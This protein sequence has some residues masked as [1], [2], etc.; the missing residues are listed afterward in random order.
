MGEKKHQLI[1]KWE[2]HP[3]PPLPH[4]RLTEDIPVA[5]WAGELVGSEDFLSLSVE[6]NSANGTSA[7]VRRSPTGTHPHP[8]APAVPC[9]SIV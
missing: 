8:L 6:H 5:T 4:P 2:L 1:S 7:D 3:P 9:Q